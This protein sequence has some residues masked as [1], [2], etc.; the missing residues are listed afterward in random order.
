MAQ[1]FLS[2]DRDQVLLLPPGLS[3]WLPAGAFAPV[4]I[5]TVAIDSTKLAANASADQNRTLEALRE[6]AGR[7]I[8]QAIETDRREDELY[9]QARGD[10]LPEELAD[11]RSR[12][13]RIRELLEQAEREREQIESERAALLAEHQRHHAETGRRKKGRPAKPEPNY[14]QRRKLAKKYNL[15]D[16]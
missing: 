14:K 15:T 5:E 7:I 6:E 16:P 8:D 9:G 4:V 3:E 13:A 12:R 2:C 1:N 10:E 11:P